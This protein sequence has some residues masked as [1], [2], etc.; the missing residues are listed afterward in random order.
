M[1]SWVMTLNVASGRRSPIAMVM[2]LSWTLNARHHTGFAGG[3]QGEPPYSAVQVVSVEPWSETRITA[4][5][6]PFSAAA[7][8]GETKLTAKRCL[9]S[10]IGPSGIRH[11]NEHVATVDEQI[12]AGRAGREDRID[13]KPGL[14]G[15]ELRLDLAHCR[16]RTGTCGLGHARKK[17]LEQK[18]I[19]LSRHRRRA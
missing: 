4:K 17:A 12:G 18:R 6:L 7:S 2:V 19:A 15:V 11:R 14:V 5:V 1:P 10:A 13:D 3:G 8:A 16:Q 9:P